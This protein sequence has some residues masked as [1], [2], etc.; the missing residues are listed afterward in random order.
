[1]FSIF[2]ELDALRWP[3]WKVEHIIV[4]AAVVSGQ[5]PSSLC[6][7]V[8]VCWELGVGSYW[9]RLGVVVGGVGLILESDYLYC[10]LLFT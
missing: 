4:V 9:E 8:C 1:M 5:R 6:V 2:N 10:V 7:C 3:R